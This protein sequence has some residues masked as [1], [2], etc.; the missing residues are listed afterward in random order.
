MPPDAPGRVN[1]W[2][3]LR[4]DGTYIVQQ[5]SREPDGE[6]LLVTRDEAPDLATARKV[7][8]PD[9]ERLGDEPARGIVIVESWLDPSLSRT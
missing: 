1:W 5:W 3:I 7:I 2:V 9:A 6:L 4:D 8:P